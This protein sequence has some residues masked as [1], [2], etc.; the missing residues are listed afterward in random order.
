MVN[1]IGPLAAQKFSAFSDA[2]CI[3]PPQGEPN[4]GASAD[5]SGCSMLG[6][7]FRQINNGRK[8]L[9]RCA[10]V[11]ACDSSRGIRK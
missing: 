10:F 5:Q 7:P 9:M 11:H 3:S 6:V 4:T 2:L 1:E 8:P